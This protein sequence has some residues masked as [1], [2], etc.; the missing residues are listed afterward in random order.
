MGR[1]KVIK[2]CVGSDGVLVLTQSRN[3]FWITQDQSTQPILIDKKHFNNERVV[4]VCTYRCGCVALSTKGNVY[5]W[6]HANSNEQDA[7]DMSERIPQMV[8]KGERIVSIS[9]GGHDYLIFATEKTVFLWEEN[10][11]RKSNILTKACEFNPPLK[12]GEKISKICCG[13]FH[14]LLLTDSGK[15]YVLDQFRGTSLIQ[16]KDC[17]VFESIDASHFSN[18][19]I[20]DI[21]CKCSFFAITKSGYV[22]SWGLNNYGQ[23]GLGDMTDRNMPHLIDRVHFKNEKIEKIGTSTFC[24]FAISE[25]GKTYVWGKNCKHELFFDDCKNRHKPTRIKKGYFNDEKII[26]FGGSLNNYFSYCC[27]FAVSK[28]GK[29]FMWGY[30]K[31]NQQNPKEP[32]EYGQSIFGVHMI[33]N[34]KMYE[35]KSFQDVG[36]DFSK[37]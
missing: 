19:K 2:A 8:F 31:T 3:I 7:H 33:T 30:S 21:E 4:D 25:S 13:I 16:G 12:N 23:L 22:Y 37:E 10:T 20:K 14:A 9:S 6:K 29:I 32:I 28:T 1:E 5:A 34:Q 24:S 36:F 18:E 11:L 26:D 35:N 27:L 17:Y 15:V